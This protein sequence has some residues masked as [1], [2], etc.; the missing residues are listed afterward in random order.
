MDI[1]NLR[2]NAD[3]GVYKASVDIERFGRT[4]RYPCEIAGPHDLDT[5]VVVKRM[6]TRALQMSD[7]PVG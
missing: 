6:H 3:K 7:T 1:R 4:F 2:Y 5:S